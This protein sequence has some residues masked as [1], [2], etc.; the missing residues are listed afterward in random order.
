MSRKVGIIVS[1]IL[2]LIF[3]VVITGTSNAKYRQASR[4]V[5][6]VK[7]ADFIPAGGEIKEQSIA[8]VKVPESIASG[9]V[10]DT[11]EVVGKK[12]RVSILKDQYIWK[13]AVGEVASKEGTVEVFIPVDAASSA[14]VMAGETVSL[15]QIDKNNNN[16]PGPAQLLCEKVRVLNSL[17]Q[18]GNEITPSPTSGISPVT[19]TKTPVTVGV[20]VQR[21]LAPKIV[22]A[23]ANKTI[24]L[25]KE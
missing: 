11:A 16:N 23:A 25:V 20:E 8:K 2:A 12:A 22:Q 9:L 6:V 18:N 7:A 14:S 15:Y 24:Y 1:L 19:A 5:E 21:D 10:T 13:D 4:T 17:D 3:T